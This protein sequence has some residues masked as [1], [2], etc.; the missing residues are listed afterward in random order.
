MTPE[1]ALKNEIMIECGRRNWICM[2]LNVGKIKLP[3]GTYFHTGVP[4]GFPDLTILT[5]RGLSF[6]VETKTHPRKPSTEQKQ[7]LHVLETR[8]FTAEVIYTFEEFLSLADKIERE[9]T[10]SK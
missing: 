7:W 1:S 9:S 4:V 5:E 3:N 6:Y 8:H 10:F 2:H